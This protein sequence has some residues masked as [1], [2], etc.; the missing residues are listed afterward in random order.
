MQK[1]FEL[2]KSFTLLLAISTGI[3]V[4]NLYYI[5]PLESIIAAEFG[6]SHSLIGVCI[7]V[8]ASWLCDWLVLFGPAG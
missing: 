1:T 3:A 8:I 2:T 7:Y 5:Q 4:A 6:V